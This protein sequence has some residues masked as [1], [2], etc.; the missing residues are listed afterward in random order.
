MSQ[1]KA[2]KMH[3]L[4]L[5]VA[6]VGLASQMCKRISSVNSLF[7]NVLSTDYLRHA[8]INSEA[9]TPKRR[10]LFAVRKHTAVKG[11]F[12]AKKLSSA[13]IRK[14]LQTRCSDSHNCIEEFSE[15][16]VKAVRKYVH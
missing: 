14:A 10:Y 15:A 3:S 1:T 7:T 2:R 13:S 9:Q 11:N 12:G 16:D 4:R 6:M 8:S 5:S